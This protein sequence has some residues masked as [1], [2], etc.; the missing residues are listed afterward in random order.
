M[1][2]LIHSGRPSVR[3]VVSDHVFI[4]LAGKSHLD[5]LSKHLHFALMAICIVVRAHA[6]KRLL[7]HFLPL[8]ELLEELLLFLWC[9]LVIQ[10]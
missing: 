2:R 7:R 8:V 10:L 4:T 5:V 3:A 6:V 1:A 9:L